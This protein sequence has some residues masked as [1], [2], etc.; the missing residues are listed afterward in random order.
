VGTGAGGQELVALSSFL[1]SKVSSTPS[2]VDKAH[3]GSSV[4]N[5]FV[6]SRDAGSAH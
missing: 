6:Y 5:V 1:P 3:V 2:Q 4:D